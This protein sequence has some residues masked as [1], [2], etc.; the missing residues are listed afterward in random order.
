MAGVLRPTSGEI[1]VDGRVSP[2]LELGAGFHPELSGEENLLLNGVL[3]GLTRR[4]VLAKREAIVA[5][6]E[7][8]DF[9]HRPLRTYS[10]G[11]I[12]RLGFSVVV[13]LAPEILLID[14]VLAVG[15]EGF[16]GKCMRKMS[17]FRASGTTM[18]FVSHNLAAVE[19]ICDRV[20]LLEAGILVTVGPPKEAVAEYMR[21]VRAAP[22]G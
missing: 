18:V 12:A 6:S 21:R 2:L 10:S 9:I 19:S 5:F 11:M 20:A 13:H 22:G 17:E 1:R 7:L 3:L 14:E 4:E 15:D 16:Q 8:G